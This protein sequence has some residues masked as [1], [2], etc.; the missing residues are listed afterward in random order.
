MAKYPYIVLPSSVGPIYKP[1]VQVNL[2]YRKTH[3]ITPKIVALVDSGA[4]VCFCAKDIGLW[5]GVQFK[6]KNKFTFTAANRTMF[7]TIKETITLYIGEKSY[8]CSFYFAESLPRET[9]IIL[10]QIG[11]FDHFKIT[12]DLKSKMMEIA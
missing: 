4:D 12:F 6:G 7:E 5:L 1:W 2:S 11:F 8:W 10:G 9:P 3:K